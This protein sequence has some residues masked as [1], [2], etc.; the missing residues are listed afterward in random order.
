MD[1]VAFKIQ[2]KI[3]SGLT[4]FKFFHK[5]YQYCIKKYRKLKTLLEK[6]NKKYALFFWDSN[7]S[8]IQYFSIE[9][10]IDSIVLKSYSIRKNLKIEN[11]I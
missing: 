1:L 9:V 8:S 7:L 4:I 3:Y 11:L 2:V 5:E 6:I 10:T